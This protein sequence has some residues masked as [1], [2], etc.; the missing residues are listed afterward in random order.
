MM[1][2]NFKSWMRA[3]LLAAGTVCVNEL[4]YENVYAAEPVKEEAA[5]PEPES[6][7]NAEAQFLFG[8]YCMEK[9][10]DEEK[11]YRYLELAAVQN[12][13][14]AWM[15]L[16]KCY[17]QRG[18]IHP[19]YLLWSKLCYMAA[20]RIKADAVAEFSIGLAEGLSGNLPEFKRWMTLAAEKGHEKAKNA[21]AS[22]ELQKKIRE[23]EE[24]CKN[25]KSPDAFQEAITA[26]FDTLWQKLG[27][28]DS[29]V[30]NEIRSVLAREPERQLI[31]LPHPEGIRM[32]G[33]KYDPAATEKLIESNLMADRQGNMRWITEEFLEKPI[34]ENLLYPNPTIRAINS[35]HEEELTKSLDKSFKRCSKEETKRLITPF[36]ETEFD[37]PEDYY[38][39]DVVWELGNQTYFRIH[40]ASE[41]AWRLRDYQ[42]FVVKDGVSVNVEIFPGPPG[43]ADADMVAGLIRDNADCWNNLAAKYADGE[44]DQ[45]CS[46]SDHAEGILLKLVKRRHAVGT[47]NLA[48]FYQDRGKTEEAKKYFALAEEFAGSSVIHPQVSLPEIFDRNGELLVKNR[49]V[50]TTRD[51]LRIYTK[52][53]RFA[54]PWIGHI[55]YWGSLTGREP[56]G[57]LRTGMEEIICRKNITHPVYLTM[58]IAL[59]TRLE[60]LIS[61]IAVKTDPRYAYGVIFSSNGEL[62]AAA[63]SSVLDL[64]NFVSVKPNPSGKRGVFTFMPVGYLFPVPDPWMRL[65]GSSSYADP[66]TKEKFQ[67]HTRPGIF[68]YEQPGIVL[69]LN[70]MK[71]NR[72]PKQVSGQAATMFKYVLAYISVAEK[73]EIP[74]P[75]VY[76]DKIN[77]PVKPVGGIEWI[78]FYR[79]PDGI[80]V[81]AIGVVKTDKPGEKLYVC[82][83]AVHEERNF[84]KPQ[85]FEVRRIAADKADKAEQLIRNFD[86]SAE[87]TAGKEK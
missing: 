68:S 74:K 49:L 75:V 10:Q 86:I 50:R 9:L 64:E 6:G 8:V 41:G 38:D 29:S 7:G 35:T 53:G 31:R 28:T 73:R 16:G 22:E 33:W 62:L 82:V 76:T 54:A 1:R 23:V 42:F 5:P 36:M 11:A 3:L 25:R 46:Y 63:Q 58:D 45:V 40:T 30:M 37:L 71:G 66:L 34:W 20:E 59:Q 48:L 57:N 15:Y 80:V 85:S 69:G 84:D 26:H 83:R 4:L 47:Y 43:I 14:D 67:L 60:S 32:E 13:R 72:D 12:Y 61:D 81:N 2:R 18:N 17:F 51:T 87:K 44:M 78:S 24:S 56:K 52:G 27:I 70:Q 65:L 19:S 39:G 55:Q 79:P 21:L 77:T